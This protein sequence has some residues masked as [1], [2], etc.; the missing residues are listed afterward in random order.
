MFSKWKKI[1]YVFELKHTWDKVMYGGDENVTR[2]SQEPC[3][4]VCSRGA[5]AQ[6]L[7]IQWLQKLP[8]VTSVNSCY[9]FPG[10]SVVKSPPANVGDS[11]SVPGL[12]RSL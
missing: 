5:T 10:G 8:P 1:E 4:L 9:S 7:L 11:G 3:G 12:G 2:G 6:D